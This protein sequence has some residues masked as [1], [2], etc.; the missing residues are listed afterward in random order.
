MRFPKG[1]ILA[2]ICFLLLISAHLYLRFQHQ[3]TPLD[4]LKKAA[5]AGD[6]EAQNDLGCYYFNNQDYQEAFKWFQKSAEQDFI[7]AYSNLGRC[8]LN[9]F[10]V[11]QDVEQAIANYKIAA[12]KGMSDAEIMLGCIYQDDRL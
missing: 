8:Y 4:L 12:E 9:G 3:D 7:T 10:G 11:E 2:N 5:E 6:V 1:L